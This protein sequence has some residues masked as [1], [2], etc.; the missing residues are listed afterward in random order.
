MEI[1]GIVQGV[2]FRPFVYNLARRL[3]LLGWVRNTSAGVDI[4]VDGALE[5]LED[6]VQVGGAADGAE[7]IQDVESDAVETEDDGME[8]QPLLL[9][10]SP[11]LT[12]KTFS[13]NGHHADEDDPDVLR[14]R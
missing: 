7:P 8:V 5:T 10:G 12:G 2:G 9:M 13:T 14:H 1:E 4:E 11:S 6:F 3:G